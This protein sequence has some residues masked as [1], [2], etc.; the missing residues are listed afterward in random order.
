M[1]KRKK[2]EKKK[3]KERN[4]KREKKNNETRGKKIMKKKVVVRERRQGWKT[5]LGR[6]VSALVASPGARSVQS[7]VDLLY[8][9]IDQFTIQK[10]GQREEETLTFVVSSPSQLF[11]WPL[12][13]FFWF[14]CCPFW[15]SSPWNLCQLM[16]WHVCVQ[17]MLMMVMATDGCSMW[18][19][20]WIL[21]PAWC[22]K[23]VVVG[24]NAGEGRW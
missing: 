4:E 14:A 15:V 2:K 21:Y 22:S 19:T 3:K 7:V 18:W 24:M 23:G 17:P 10:K 6:W 11:P 1:N 16:R 9:I 13:L 5:H 12:P 8:K 20:C